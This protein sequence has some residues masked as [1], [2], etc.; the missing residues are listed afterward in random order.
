M[1][2]AIAAAARQQSSELNLQQELLEELMLE[3]GT[4]STLALGD[5]TNGRCVI[6]CSDAP[7]VWAAVLVFSSTGL[8]LT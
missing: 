1:P 2:V 4:W 6:S 8:I 3:T 7:D 5:G